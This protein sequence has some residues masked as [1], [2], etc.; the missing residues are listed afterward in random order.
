MAAGHK[1]SQYRLAREGSGLQEHHSIVYWCVVAFIV[2]FLFIAPFQTALFYGSKAQYESPIYSSM[3]W[4]SVFSLLAAAYLF[5][6]WRL[7][8]IRDLYALAVWGIPLSYF[9]S[10]SSAATRHHAENLLL[11][12]LMY[13]LFFVIG[14]YFS[15]NRIGNSILR[16]GIV[17]SAYAVVVY[18]LMNVF[19]NVYFYDAVMKTGEGLRLTSVFQYANAYAG[20][21]IIPLLC[22]LYL[23][24]FSRKWYA[25]A[26]HALMLV[27]VLL[28]FFLTLSRGGLVMLPFILLAFL[29]FLSF[30]RQILFFV[31]LIIGSAAS[32]LI[33]DKIKNIASDVLDVMVERRGPDFEVTDTLSFFDPLSFGGWSLLLST[34]VVVCAVV[35]LVHKLL[36]PLLDRGLSRIS[37]AR[38]ANLY[39]PGLIVLGVLLG[40][41]LIAGNA[42]I[43]HI[44]PEALAQRV[45][46]INLQQH[47]VLERFTMY[48]DTFKALKDYP[49]FGAG[50]NAWSVLYPQ[51][52]N[53]PYTVNQVHS[54]VLQY[55]VET[56]IV[57]LL[58]LLSF[59]GS[60]LYRFAKTYFVSKPADRERNLVFY[61]AA[62]AILFHSLMDFEMTYAYISAL[63]FLSLGGMASGF[64]SPISERWLSG[65]EE[66]SKYGLPVVLGLLS[67]AL[68]VVSVIHGQAYNHYSAAVQLAQQG[69]TLEEVLVP[70]DKAIGL[71]PDNPYYVLTKVDFLEQVYENT[72]NEAHYEKGS[73]LL[74]SIKKTEPYDRVVF[75]ARYRHYMVKDRLADALAL[76]KEGLQTYP[77]VIGMYER[78]AA[79][80]LQLGEQ[81][82]Q[83]GQKQTMEGHWNAAVELHQ[84]VLARMKQLESLPEGQMAGSPFY[85]TPNLALTLGQ[86]Y[87]LKGDAAKSAE[88]L[89]TTIGDQLEEAV[90]K[91]GTRWY[92]AALQKSG[93]PDRALYDRFT[94]NYPDEKQEIETIVSLSLSL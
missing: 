87:Y 84:E 28:S 22:G 53:N 89:S 5:K 49:L 24:V 17:G 48:K 83:A 21:L 92:L 16:Y 55:M 43:V 61:A 78:A 39:V 14:L 80:H 15:R 67:A 77:W 33:T 81:Y 11:L 68:L 51:Y 85:V 70:L 56:G 9:I 44:L 59:I 65:K 52:A 1:K 29:P 91:P 30:A 6:S 58:I 93:K 36:P 46:S 45:Q 88:I 86:T 54:F 3:I 23:I 18:C 62:V 71:Q 12:Q 37:G 63:V 26:I 10:L 74:E 82:W 69:R 47:S 4:T 34:S 75:E 72:H 31:Y 40:A 38:L 20:F 19:G 2:S 13:A 57:G 76:M 35:V 64:A 42:A 90:R 7:R 50:G 66:K 41:G 8:E 73:G 79:L 60:I 25:T 27:P 32:F 94:A